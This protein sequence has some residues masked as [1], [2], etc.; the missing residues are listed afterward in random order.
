MQQLQNQ[1]DSRV[2]CHR[3]A[4]DLLA[5]VPSVLRF[6]RHQMRR[7]RQ[8]ELT[9][10]QFRALVF[11]NHNVNASLSDM[12]DVLGLS[13]P[14]TSRMVELLVRRGWM[15]RRARSSDRRCVSLSLTGRGKAVFR[16]AR[17]AT[18]VALSQRLKTLSAGELA[19]VSG[20]M[21]VLSR[22]FAPENCHAEAVK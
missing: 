3:C 15:R 17:E 5:G 12:A 2:S 10:P 22:A 16:M 14:A 9:V 7:H 13:L 20:A 11:L 19:L 21:Q 6:I 18:Q 1:T 4:R 8:S